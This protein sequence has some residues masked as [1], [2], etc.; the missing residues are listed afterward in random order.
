[1]NP[2]TRRRARLAAAALVCVIAATLALIRV[3]A[4]MT[5]R[6]QGAGIVLDTAG[7]PAAG[8]MAVLLLSPPPDGPA[9]D[10][11]FRTSPG[12]G[13]APAPASV[14]GAS[15]AYVVRACGRLGPAQ[16]IRLGL[17]ATSRP[18]HATG[19]LILRSQG[20]GDTI[21]AISLLG[22]HPAPPHWGT[23]ADRLPT[24]TLPKR[25]PAQ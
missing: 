11:L 5:V 23:E 16:A 8:V 18:P 4:L 2:R 7:E 19:W 14:S 9:R 15:G 25:P 21:R 3:N 24:V 17:D 1:M 6:Y 20:R 12:C 22:W 10:A 13:T